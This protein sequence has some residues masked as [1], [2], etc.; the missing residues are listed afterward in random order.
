M[1]NKTKRVKIMTKIMELILGIISGVNS[2]IGL[3][4]IIVIIYN[5]TF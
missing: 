1:K 3:I 2:M 4:K 5:W